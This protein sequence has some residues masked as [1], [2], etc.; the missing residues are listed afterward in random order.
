MAAGSS[1][2]GEGRTVRMRGKRAPGLQEPTGGCVQGA[3]H[4]GTGGAGEQME[5][6]TNPV[7]LTIKSSS[8]QD[9]HLPQKAKQGSSS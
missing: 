2:S 8:L 3:R 7:H 5:V 9:N 1:R 4:L 6:H